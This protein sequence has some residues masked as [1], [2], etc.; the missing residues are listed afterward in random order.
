MNAHATKITADKPLSQASVMILERLDAVEALLQK[1]LTGQANSDT[2]LN[3]I[4]D[5]IG[6]QAPAA[7]APITPV[8]EAPADPELKLTAH[9]EARGEKEIPR[10]VSALHA[11]RT[12]AAGEYTRGSLTP[13]E[14]DAIL[15]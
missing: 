9:L 4:L 8:A 11:M 10:L 14:A 6:G 5:H 13:T 2:A 3:L 1:L 12:L 15:D 7:P